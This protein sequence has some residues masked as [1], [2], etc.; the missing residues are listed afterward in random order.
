MPQQAWG[1]DESDNI[2]YWRRIRA[3]E[4]EDTPDEVKLD[5]QDEEAK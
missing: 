5:E 1:D 4:T 3:G 2:D